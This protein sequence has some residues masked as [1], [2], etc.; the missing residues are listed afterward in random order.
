MFLLSKKRMSYLFAEVFK[1][2]GEKIKKSIYFILNTIHVHTFH[3][4]MHRTPC[5]KNPLFSINFFILEKSH[6]VPKILHFLWIYQ[7]IRDNYIEAISNF[8]KNNP[9]YE[10]SL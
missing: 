1:E 8:E 5:A 3:A 2:D 9:N 6:I 10:V 4:Y 7:P